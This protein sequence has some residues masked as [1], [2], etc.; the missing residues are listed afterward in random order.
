MIRVSQELV[1]FNEVTNQKR[2]L[3]LGYKIFLEKLERKEQAG[4][5]FR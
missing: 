5:E 4:N 2:V 3:G 1:Y